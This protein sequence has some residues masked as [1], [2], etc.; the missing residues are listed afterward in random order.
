[1][2]TATRPL[3]FK[4]RSMSNDNL[5]NLDKSFQ[6]DY[7]VNFDIIFDW[8]MAIKK[9]SYTV[10][11]L[12]GYRRI[13]SPTESEKC[14]EKLSK[15]QIKNIEIYLDRL[16]ENDDAA[17]MVFSEVYNPV[18][19]NE[20]M[21]RNEQ[22]GFIQD[23]NG[24]KIPKYQ[25]PIIADKYEQITAEISEDY[26]MPL[27]EI[28]NF[29][30][31]C[32]SWKDC[33]PHLIDRSVDGIREISSLL[34]CSRPKEVPY[35]RI[36]A[37]RLQE[38]LK[39]WIGCKKELDEKRSELNN[40]KDTEEFN[41]LVSCHEQ[42][43]IDGFSINR[44]SLTKA[45]NHL[46]SG[47]SDKKNELYV[48]VIIDVLR[49]L[50][51]R[52]FL[53]GNKINEKKV[54]SA[55]KMIDARNKLLKMKVYPC[56]PGAKAKLEKKTSHQKLSSSSSYAPFDLIVDKKGQVQFGI[57]KFK[58]QGTCFPTQQVKDLKIWKNKKV[59]KHFMISFRSGHNK[60]IIAKISS[61]EFLKNNRGIFLVLPYTFEIQ[62]KISNIEWFFKSAQKSLIEKYNPLLPDSLNIAAFDLNMIRVIV[63]LKCRIYRNDNGSLQVR[64][65]GS[66]DLVGDPYISE[67]GPN[68]EALIR[69]KNDM[70]RLG[71]IIRDEKYYRKELENDNVNYVYDLEFAGKESDRA[72]Y[73][74][75]LS[76]FGQGGEN[77]NSAREGL[78][79]LIGVSA[80]ESLEN[81][82]WLRDIFESYTG[83]KNKEFANRLASK[84]P[85][86]EMPH[87]NTKI[88]Y[89][90]PRMYRTYIDAATSS[91]KKRLKDLESSLM[92]EGYQ[93]LDDLI[94][95]LQ[96]RDADNA[97]KRATY[98]LH[99]KANQ[100]ITRGEV[101]FR[102]RDKFR[103]FVLE[104]IAATMVKYCI[105]YDI[106]AVFIE[107]LESS[108][109]EDNNNSLTRIF[110]GSS[111]V[112]IIREA[113]EKNQ[114]AC[115]EVDK[116]GTSRICSLNGNLS[117]RDRKDKNF[118]YAFDSDGKLI[119][120]DCDLSAAYR[121]LLTG[122]DHSITPYQFYVVDPDEENATEDNDKEF[123][124]RLK[125]FFKEKFDCSKPY[126]FKN[127]DGDV[128]A[129]KS[130]PKTGRIKGQYIYYIN[131]QLYSKQ[132]KESL[133]DEIKE[134]IKQCEVFG[135]KIEDRY[136]I[137]FP[138][139]TYDKK[140]A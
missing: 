92:K 78:D 115:I 18:G 65:Y 52:I 122:L 33:R 117:Y 88:R 102:C 136:P 99:Y 86:D 39:S 21:M 3:K 6:E 109:G 15:K 114:V 107:D 123:G 97:L 137:P 46:K 129:L 111:L 42:V 73:K 116:R 22:G 77:K 38:Q 96:V 125:E 37:D 66:G 138:I 1:L 120:Y 48:Q 81:L 23:T 64:G 5:I 101:K 8:M 87:S 54:R 49:N 13:V 112:K 113:L 84:L 61:L 63:G 14:L 72:S 16:L 104:R 24:K 106:D 25:F 71:R 57:E 43:K 131:G 132:Q 135:I 133:E 98:C 56:R 60:P 11:D 35:C 79:L 36:L 134:E 103:K 89:V 62:E 127:D 130:K 105:K 59:D 118:A 128:M 69:L 31:S 58:I 28:E 12:D 110:R 100:K 67:K 108:Y 124:K 83:D 51:Y 10:E 44:K 2:N 27:R 26:G 34:K 47:N 19:P 9:Y 75:L 94:C 53:N 80:R 70:R 91:F 85:R 29:L 126:F 41:L 4:I 93:N 7:R 40:I 17:Y 119:A 68:A 121:I 76:M 82:L 90:G 95:L 55:C 32:E 50:N 45:L 140:A 74:K 20:P 139:S 30:P